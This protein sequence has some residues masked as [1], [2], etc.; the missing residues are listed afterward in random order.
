MSVVQKFVAGL[1]WATFT[2]EV[3]GAMSTEDASGFA[4]QLYAGIHNSGVLRINP[5]N[6]PNAVV[7]IKNV[8]SALQARGNSQTP[9]V[10]FVPVEESERPSRPRRRGLRPRRNKNA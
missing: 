9:A 4:N 8:L 5:K 6:P 3:I 10:E 2:P 1:E 7:A